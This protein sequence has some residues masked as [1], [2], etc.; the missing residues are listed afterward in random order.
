[1]DYNLSESAKVV[2]GI[3]DR[4]SKYSEVTQMVTNLGRID[5]L[6]LGTNL[7]RMIERFKN[8]FTGN[9]EVYNLHDIDMK[10]GCQGCIHC[11]FDNKCVYEGKDGY[12]DFFNTKLKTADII[13]F[14][15]TIIDRYFSSTWKT[16]FDR[17]F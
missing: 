1:M 11:G 12:I 4:L 17:S 8:S 15:G 2:T 9:V 16:F 10:G 7:A 3:Q 5:E 13:I 6:S 14:A